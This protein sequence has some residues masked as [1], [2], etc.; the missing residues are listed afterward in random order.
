MYYFIEFHECQIAI[1]KTRRNTEYMNI[2]P[3]I[4]RSVNII[5]QTL[6]L[7]EYRFFI[8]IMYVSSRQHRGF[9]SP[10]RLGLQ[11]DYVVV[12]AA[13]S[14][15]YVKSHGPSLNVC[16]VYDNNSC[17][18]VAMIFSLFLTKVMSLRQFA[19]VKSEIMT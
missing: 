14:K 9:V 12:M 6:Q 16:V 15:L 7:F 10:W 17:A 3:I 19:R 4:H 11:D 13:L 1:Y 18:F 5:F 2:L 8:N